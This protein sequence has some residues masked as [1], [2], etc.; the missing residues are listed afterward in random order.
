M[1]VFVVFQRKCSS[2]G[3][4]LGSECTPK[5]SINFK[6][7]FILFVLI[8]GIISCCLQL[9][10]VANSFKDFINSIYTISA[11]LTCTIC[12]STLI[13]KMSL[14][15]KYL[16]KLEKIINKSESVFNFVFDSIHN[17]MTKLFDR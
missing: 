13:W 15:S 10:Y 8:C 2:L 9:F 3:I 17:A 11:L 5:N 4:Y 16:E 14:L 6:N 7:R 12:F 1:K